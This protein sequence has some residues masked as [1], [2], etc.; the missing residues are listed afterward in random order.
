MYMV[1]ALW[2]LSYL[3][4]FAWS[5]FTHILNIIKGQYGELNGSPEIIDCLLCYSYTFLVLQLLTW[6][7]VEK[8]N[9]DALLMTL[10]FLVKLIIGQ[11]WIGSSTKALPSPSET[12]CNRSHAFFQLSFCVL[13]FQW[14]SIPFLQLTSQAQ[15]KI[16]THT[17]THKTCEQSNTY[18]NLWLF[19]INESYFY[20]ALSPP[21]SISSVRIL[22]QW[23]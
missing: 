12:E 22:A 13:S 20:P 9:M 18:V 8:A 21:C 15:R 4:N 14:A 6:K 23:R 3:Q 5:H 16:C 11:N 17:H 19:F 7:L 10:R 1:A 2:T